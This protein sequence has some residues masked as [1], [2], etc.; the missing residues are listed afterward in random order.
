LISFPSLGTRG[1]LGNQLFQY[2]FLRTTARRLQTRF[3]C[4]EWIGDR[5]FHLD[6]AGERI[7]AQPLAKRYRQSRTDVGFDPR[8]GR[9]ED[10]TEI[11]G[12]FQSARNF[13]ELSARRWY[14]FREE[15]VAGVAARFAHLDLSDS[16]GLHLRFG[17]KRHDLRFY[18]PRPRYY[19]GALARLPQRSHILVFSDDAD[20][21][22]SYLWPL[23]E[24]AVFVTGNEPYEDLYLMSRCRD[25][26]SSPSTLSWWGAWLNA[27]A[28]KTIVAPREGVLRPGAPAVSTDFWPE[29]WVRMRSLAPFRGYR[30]A[31]LTQA[32]LGTRR[33][34]EQSEVSAPTDTNRV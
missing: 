3:H 2:A 1:R 34:V 28:D 7:D 5:V 21:G 24:R 12:F 20:R 11:A 27:R 25:F 6:D 33:G 10:G 15:V 17:D 18:L 32:L 8:A 19:E 26:I 29:G 23:R 13:D 31:R 9:I 30:M 14:R 4:P 22:V 16:V